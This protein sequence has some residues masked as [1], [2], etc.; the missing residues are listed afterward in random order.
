MWCCGEVVSAWTVERFTKSDMGISEMT[1]R[2]KRHSIFN[3]TLTVSMHLAWGTIKL[4]PLISRLFQKI[5]PHSSWLS[6]LFSRAFSRLHHLFWLMIGSFDCQ[7]VLWLAR[8][9]YLLWHLTGLKWAQL[10]QTNHVPDSH[11]SRKLDNSPKLHVP[12]WVVV[13]FITN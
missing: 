4:R 11:K 8:S 10:C 13:P 1:T 6:E 3:G 12:D 9:N 5:A 2:K 7:L